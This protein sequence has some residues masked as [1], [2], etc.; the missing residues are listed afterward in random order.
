MSL[1]F[2]VKNVLV[3][4]HSS[5]LCPNLNDEAKIVA[6]I[7][8]RRVSRW[9]DTSLLSWLGTFS[10]AKKFSTIR[11]VKKFPTSKKVLNNWKGK[12]FPTSQNILNI[13]KGKKFPTSQ[14]ILHNLQVKRLLT[15]IEVKTFSTMRKVI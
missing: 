8:H 13:S 12:K 9:T 7:D 2:K 4:K 15:N 14:N 6:V 1:T 11:K 10:A 3:D 5:L